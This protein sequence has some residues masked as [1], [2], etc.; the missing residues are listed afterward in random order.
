MRSHSRHVAPLFSALSFAAFT[1]VAVT[2]SEAAAQ[3]PQVRIVEDASGLLLCV[4]VGLDLELMAD[5]SDDVFPVFAVSRM[6][7]KRSCFST[8]VGSRRAFGAPRA[9]PSRSVRRAA[10]PSPSIGP[11][12]RSGVTTATSTDR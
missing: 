1:A 3:Q 10:W 12:A 5:A 2:P 11:R 8:A 6:A 9:A 4:I 7:T